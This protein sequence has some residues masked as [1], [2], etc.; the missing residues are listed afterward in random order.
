MFPCH[1]TIL[2]TVETP[3]TR[4]IQHDIFSNVKTLSLIRSETLGTRK[5]FSKRLVISEGRMDKSEM[6]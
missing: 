6:S 1:L 3:C 4:S 2:I 5:A